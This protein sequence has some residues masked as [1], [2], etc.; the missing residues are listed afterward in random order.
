[1][2]DGSR[3]IFVSFEPGHGGHKI[4][5][6]ISCLP[7]IHWYSHRDNGINPCNVYYKHTDIRQRHVSRYHYDR[8]VPKGSL[9]PLHDY[10]KDFIPDEEHYYNR[11]FYPRF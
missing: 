1:M 8:L 2:L 7:D 5:R 9:P 4:G 6:V 11:F 10:V 3:F